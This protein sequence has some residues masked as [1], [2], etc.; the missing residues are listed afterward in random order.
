MTTIAG[1]SAT[2]QKVL[3]QD[4]TS[5]SVSVPK[6]R[7]VSVQ[8]DFR[9]VVQITDKG[10]VL[11]GFNR[12]TATGKNWFAE[13][14]H[15]SSAQSQFQEVVLGPGLA[16]RFGSVNVRANLANGM[17]GTSTGTLQFLAGPQIFFTGKAGR[18][19]WVF[20]T[21]VLRFEHQIKPQKRNAF[22]W[23]SEGHFQVHGPWWFGGEFGA[24]KAHGLPC[25]W[26]GGPAVRFKQSL[27]APTFEV[28]AQQ[29]QA[30]A[31]FLRARAILQLR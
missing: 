7:T 12:L 6:P 1:A 4:T 23:R 31:Q 18:H 17:N 22:N 15:T 2:T 29:N 20:A 13:A 26:S 8:T 27:R 21:P 28:A 11:T 3:G 16:R 5:V 14:I 24:R 25:T 10:P 30:G 9:A 19:S